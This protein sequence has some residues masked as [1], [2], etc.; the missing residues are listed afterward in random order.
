[1]ELIGIVWIPGI[2]RIVFANGLYDASYC[3]A[4]CAYTTTAVSFSS[5][6]TKNSIGIEAQ[7]QS[8]NT[9][10]LTEKSS[11]YHSIMFELAN[12]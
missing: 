7:E 4:Y 10:W 2:A 5:F 12:L 1:M 8:I 11:R 3:E 6:S 9:T